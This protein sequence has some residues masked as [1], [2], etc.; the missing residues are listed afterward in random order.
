MSTTAA[1]AA[2]AATATTNAT[3]VTAALEATLR[4]ALSSPPLEYLEI[5]NESY[6]HKGGK[7]AETH[8]QV[9]VVAPQFQGLSLI[10]RH[11]LIN[12]ACQA[13]NLL[14]PPG[15]IHA[16]SIVAKTPEQWQQVVDP[17]GGSSTI[18]GT[19]NCRGGDK[20]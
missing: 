6:K 4:Q 1:A 13:A 9:I 20:K 19:P 12:Q 10:Q 3:T 7:N 11:R 15:S 17:S 2:N 16:L 14:D 18:A 5:R 8:F